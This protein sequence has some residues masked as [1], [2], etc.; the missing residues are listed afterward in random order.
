MLGASRKMILWAL[1][2]ST[3]VFLSTVTAASE[4]PCRLWLAPSHLSTSDKTKF[5]L[6]AGVEF[7]EN[8]TLPNPEIGV[9]IVDLAAR[10]YRGTEM[11]DLHKEV[12]DYLENIVW[13]SRYAG[14][15]YE[16]DHSTTVFA[17]GVAA[18]ANYHSG[19]HNV[20]W[21]Q[22]SVLLRE[23][24]DLIEPGKYS[25]GRGAYTNYYNMTM[26]A[27]KRIP[28][29]MELFVNIGDAWNS[30]SEKE[31]VYQDKLTRTDYEN[32]DVVLE[33]ILAFQE[34][35]ESHMKD[36]SVKEEVL[37]FMLEVSLEG[38]GEKRAKVIRSLLPP[39]W[40][41]LEKAAEMGGTFAYR[42]QD[43]VQSLKWLETHGLCVDNLR[44]GKS[45]V[46]DA[47]RGAFA[48][49]KILKGET[50]SPVVM[51]PVLSEDLMDM[52]ELVEE[53]GEGDKPGKGAVYDMDRPRG[54]QLLL[55]YAFGHYESSML[56]IPA[57]PMISLINHGSTREGKSN[58]RLSWSEHAFLENDHAVQ[59]IPLDEW[60]LEYDPK[61][62]MLLNA[63]RDIEKDEEIFID[64]GP[65][66]VEAWNK[67]V[68]AFRGD[69]SW[70]LK[71]EDARPKYKNQ[72]YPV[73]L[74]K[75]D[76]PYPAGVAT[77]CFIE[78]EEV[79]DG[80]PTRSSEGQSILQ[81]AG[82]ATLEEYKGNN[83]DVC[84]LISRQEDPE[85][86]YTY[87]VATRSKEEEKEVIIVK[88]VPHAAIWLVDRPYS[89]DIHAK[90]VFRQWIAIEDELFPQAWRDLRQE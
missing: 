80:E 84:D 90:G 15:H 64:Y 78:S 8:E 45:S 48:S 71:A 34:K 61:V 44:S 49:R 17:P 63:T 85:H 33:R 29:G 24:E 22:S 12:L 54:K 21:L 87:T 16:G 13:M 23:W 70:P 76:M 73:D 18:L 26:Q 74:R 58:A 60:D 43:I 66:W 10:N 6:F 69:G 72:P 31:D 27:T 36:G 82:P 7:S 89:S 68:S 11:Y 86:F 51:I 19:Y 42:N 4:M 37:D 28:V 2:A 65:A 30:D 50:I 53:K 62:I 47:G 79:P 25:P 57:S 3:S 81:W 46:P 40:S 1:G 67:H 9:P 14:A 83:M 20:D 52:Y 32:A 5:G 41:K 39:K 56:L 38:A 55:N 77:T 35:Y 59:D 88:G 75:D